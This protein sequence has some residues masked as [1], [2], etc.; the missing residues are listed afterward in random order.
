MTVELRDTQVSGGKLGGL[1][2]FRGSALDAVQDQLGQLAIGLALA[3]N[4]QN[5]EGLDLNGQPGG[6]VFDIQPPVAIPNAKN[7]GN[8]DIASAYTDASQIQASATRSSMTRPM[9]TR[10]RGCPT[11]PK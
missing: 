8:V 9:A 10:S 6:A 2:S 1:L 4:A 5:A 3:V 11:T 7:S